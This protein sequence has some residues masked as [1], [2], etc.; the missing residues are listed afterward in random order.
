MHIG[1]EMSCVKCFFMTVHDSMH[2]M[3]HHD[4]TPGTMQAHVLPGGTFS[5]ILRA[6]KLALPDTALR[7][8]VRKS[9]SGG[10]YYGYQQRQRSK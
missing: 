9:L 7:F 3:R 5:A 4:V 1:R 8:E 2:A 6:T 10:G